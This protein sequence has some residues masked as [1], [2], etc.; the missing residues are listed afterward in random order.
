MSKIADLRF[1][2][3]IVNTKKFTDFYILSLYS[4]EILKL[5]NLRIKD[6]KDFYF[7][8]RKINDEIDKKIKIKK[9]FLNSLFSISLIYCFRSIL[10]VPLFFSS[11]YI[12]KKL[13]KGF[14]NS[15]IS[16]EHINDSC[17]FCQRNL[18]KQNTKEK[19]SNYYILIKHLLT[20]NSQINNINDF[21]KE[22]D[23]LIKINNLEYK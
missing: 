22:L 18:F 3:E 6:F 9:H 8:N 20:K 12:F 10:I 1:R 19:F 15:F 23:Y 4:K 17:Y 14:S 2:D 5:D 13:Y 16:N 11:V 21:E 7:K